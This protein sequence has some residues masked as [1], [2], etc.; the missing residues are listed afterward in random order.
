[1]I[2][3]RTM[4]CAARGAV[5][6]SARLLVLALA[7]GTLG[8]Q[9]VSTAQGLQAGS[10]WPMFR[11]NTLHTGL[12]IGSGATST[13]KWKFVTGANVNGSPA[14]GADGTIYV[15]SY[16]DNVYAIN[17][18]D[19]SQKWKF[20][21][22]NWVQTSPAIGADGTIYIGSNDDNVY[23]INSADGSQ[24]WM[25]ITKSQVHSCPAIGVDGTIYVGSTDDNLYALN[26]ADGSQKWMFTTGGAVGSS[27]A[28]GAD[29]TIYVGS[30][31]NNLYAI[32]PVDGSQKWKFTTGASVW[33][34][35]AV[36]A[37][38]TI[39]VGSNDDNLYAIN[40]ADGSQKWMFTTGSQIMDSSPAIAADGTIYV[41]SEDPSD[42]LYAINPADGSQK[43][44]FTTGGKVDSS[45]TIGSD[46]T[47]YVGSTDDNLYAIN[48][49]DGSQKWMFTTGGTVYSSAAI[50]TDGTL[51]VGSDDYNVYA[52]GKPT[53][54]M[55]LGSSKTPSVIGQSVTFAATVKGSSGT[56][57]GTVSFSDGTTLLSSATLSNK[58]LATYKTSTL[59]FGSHTIEANYSGDTSFNSATA[60]LTQVVLGNTSVTVAATPNPP[61]A[62]QPVSLTATVVAVSPATG[63]PS[64]T[65]TFTD[66]AITLGTAALTGGQA[67]LT[68][69]VP[70]LPAG[71]QTITASF[72]G[73][74]LFASASGTL[75]EDLLY[76]AAVTL[77][78]AVNPSLVGQSAAFT[79]TVL[80]VDPLT[81]TPTGTVTFSDG[82]VVL[83]TATLVN[84]QASFSTAPLALGR[85]PITATYGGD[86]NFASVVS[87]TLTQV[88]LN[89]PSVTV[90][91]SLNPATTGQT[92]TFTAAV[93]PVAPAKGTPTGVVTFT[94]GVFIL[95]TSRLAN[96]QATFSTSILSSGTH[97]IYAVYGG[98]TSFASTSSAALTQSILNGS[99][100]TLASS[101][102]PSVLFQ[103]VTFTAS[104]GPVTAGTG[105]PTG[106]V[107]FT[108]GSMPIGA[109]PIGNG[110]A[111]L[112]IAALAAGT[113]SIVASY[114]GN[115]SF[116]GAA[117]AAVTQ[118]V[119]TT[120]S[121]SLT[122]SLSPSVSGQ[123]VTF[124]AVVAAIAPNTGV[125]TGSVT[126]VNGSIT[127]GSG[128]LSNG[129]AVFSTAALAPGTHNITA[130]YSGDAKFTN[131]NSAPI[132]QV[133]ES[134]PSV[135]LTTSQSLTSPGQPVAF[136]ATVAAVQPNTGT[137]T[138][139]VV[140]LDGTT[141]L[142]TV[143]LS[144]GQASFPTPAL[145]L[146]THSITASYGGN[147]SFAPAVSAT[148]IQTVLNTA[149]VQLTSSLNP[150]SLS[151]SVTFT[152]VAAPA[153][154]AAGVPTG[155]VLFTDGSTPLARIPLSNGQAAFTTAI[156]S[157]GSHAIAAQYVG[158]SS[159]AS[160]SSAPLA[161]SV[162]GGSVVA[163]SSSQNPAVLGQPLTFSATVTGYPLTAGA[164]TGEVTF[165]DGST[166]LGTKLL[167]KGSASFTTST[168]P[169]GSHTI[170]VSYDGNATFA[171]A[172]SPNLAQVILSAP[173]ISLV[174]SLNPSLFGQAVTLSATVAAIAPAA[175]SPS[176]TVTFSDGATL[177]AIATVINGAASFTTSSL[178]AGSH[179]MLASY[180]GDSSFA[181][182]SSSTLRQ[183]VLAVPTLSIVSA[184]N[185]ALF[186]QSVTFTAT[187]EHGTQSTA[188]PTGTITFR[189][190]A[191][192]LGSAALS[193]GQAAFTTSSLASGSH[194][195]SASYSGSASFAA[196][197]PASLTEYILAVP[198]LSVVCSP[199]PSILG[200]AVTITA[201]VAAPKNS[202][203]LPTGSITFA[204]G[205]TTIGSA[206]IS[207]GQGVLMTSGLALGS[208]TITASYGGDLNFAAVG[209]VS[210]PQL[211]M[212]GTTIALAASPNPSGP[213]Q[214]VTFTAT[215]IPAVPATGTPTG[216]VTFS[217]GGTAL[218]TSTLT[219]GQAVLSIGT[220]GLGSS[221]VTAVYSGD[222]SFAAGQSSLTQVVQAP[223][224]PADVSVGSDNRARLLWAHPGGSAYLWSVDRI[225]GAYTAGPN[226]GPYS[227][228]Q[229]TRLACGSDGITH[230]LW[231]RTD[232]A[233]SLW[234]VNSDNTFRS[235]VIY[236]PFAG[237]VAADIAVGSD[238]L[239]RILWTNTNDGRAVVW[240]VNAAGVRSN[241]QNFY[242]PY[243]GYTAVGL[244]CGTDGLTRL[245][246]ANPQGM[247][248]LWIMN[249][250]NQQQSFTLYGP[251]TGW[252]PT[253][254]GV[255]SD[256]LARVLW[257]NSVDGRAVVWS[258]D[259]NGVRSNDQNFYGPFPGYTAQ[260]LACGAD[261]FTRL[262]WNNPSG[263]TSFWHMT[264]DNTL[265]TF[266]NYGPS[267]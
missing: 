53:P 256:N 128:A 119:L 181:A 133:V 222:A 131:A 245:I 132:A 2:R 162:L 80:A 161:Q 243:P 227:T 73:G 57:T 195:I 84:S 1:M 91:S 98:D 54:T 169:A 35:P 137:P 12:G 18:A 135:T 267:F 59:T 36:G 144:N 66:G 72:S 115:A 167:V 184:P 264:A 263:I 87:T 32:N 139:V 249:P 45:P 29:G 89:L 76:P 6:R 156:L 70:G 187:V 83:G 37:D 147:S 255:G 24:K 155:S 158:S 202:T 108:D 97:S 230:I 163:F 216:D 219:N 27:P 138:G 145:S 173:A 153:S 47:I 149:T 214:T 200:Q 212:S 130:S 28:I 253:D 218:G 235:S 13:L 257:T 229:A 20:T 262:F 40:P 231:N 117:S 101:A 240:S 77:I 4:L 129:Q 206:A 236:G 182:V 241:D 90:V 165:S 143:A 189:N 170:S 207:L 176:G 55:T 122:S 213:G 150:S 252:I 209:P 106:S 41:G 50:G 142:G 232:G 79:A 26:P 113:H 198:A 44:M 93:A 58:G 205:K 110:K 125:P 33:S 94:D 233:L 258:V 69:S 221:T 103:A 127:L 121:V 92:V 185:Q 179:N 112:T 201:T 25:F 220:L 177:L 102:N 148:V 186:G 123:T 74:A 9:T 211:V 10:P 234:W 82:N 64:G 16:D 204:D 75:A 152:A 239:I 199:N 196:G 215:V 246:W 248:S 140:F 86:T 3:Q 116:S 71:N 118:I 109:V 65:V 100:I 261:G 193:G 134:V 34:S 190:G 15:G 7:A 126:F 151:R 166:V 178:A 56:P 160:A 14:I 197:T 180:G 48:P 124:T 60:T 68:I 175:G 107:I 111:A 96:G 203:S 146:G 251:Y 157:A 250:D 63:T 61:T 188:T 11:Q 192:V 266:N 105:T 242:G 208:H 159:F 194:T 38:G 210:A 99:K 67:V 237:W 247:A 224:L 95:G 141:P 78:S 51:Y 225:S 114:G 171:G 191:A 164:P 52:L 30:G 85:H 136:T 260:K 226:F 183:V 244:A 22:G 17:P 21:T 81:G 5:R 120:P 49:A 217:D 174:S 259:T 168:L 265:L 104:V 172:V 46:G 8:S 238:N 88:V 19:G 223:W 31:D 39:Y 23:A 228:Y 62:G 43:W 154:L 42:S 254:I